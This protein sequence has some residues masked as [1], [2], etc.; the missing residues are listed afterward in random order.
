VKK[1]RAK[2]LT[3]VQI[4]LALAAAMAISD[5]PDRDHLM[6]LISFRAGLRAQEIARLDHYD[7]TDAQGKLARSLEVSKRGAKYGRPRSVPMHP[8]LFDALTEYIEKRS[9]KGGPLFYT[10]FGSAMTPNAVQKQIGRIFQSA[11]FHGAS[12]HSGRRT[13]ITRA[14]QQANQVRCSIKDVQALAG[15]ADLSTTGDYIE[16]SPYQ[17]DLVNTLYGDREP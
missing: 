16:P 15:H 2:I 17:V 7:V 14:A 6:L 11:G 5:D 1:R 13:F 12:S 3:E 8:D 4:K 9:V 10:R